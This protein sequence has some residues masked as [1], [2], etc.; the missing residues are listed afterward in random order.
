MAESMFEVSG[1]L[2]PIIAIGGGLLIPIVAIIA[3]SWHRMRHLELEIGLK[4]EMIARGMSAEEIER[5]IRATGPS[6]SDS[7]H[8]TGSHADS[9]V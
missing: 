9:R 3:H 6:G 5:V 8:K 7:C 1:T 2:I 4:N